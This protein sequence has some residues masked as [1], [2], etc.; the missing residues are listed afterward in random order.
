MR[1]TSFGT[2]NTGPPSVQAKKIDSN[3]F[4]VYKQKKQGK[5]GQQ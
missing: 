5:L 2:R 3:L 1:K 4:T